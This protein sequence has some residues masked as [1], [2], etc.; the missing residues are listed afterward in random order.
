LTLSCRF[1]SFA[2]LA[3]I[4]LTMTPLV[5]PT[6]HAQS[7]VTL[8]PGPGP[9]D[10]TDNGSANAGK[11]AMVS[12]GCGDAIASGAN[13]GTGSTALV[14]TSDCNDCTFY[15]YVQFSTAGMPTTNI[16]TA[17]IYLH[18]GV[19]H[20]GCWMWPSNPTFGM[21]RVTGAWAENAITY[22]SQPA[23]DAT[24]VDSQTIGGIQGMAM[25]TTISNWV[26]F[27]VTSLYRNWVS[28][29]VPNNGVRIS[30]DNPFCQN[31]TSAWFDT[32]DGEGSSFRPYLE[33]TS[34]AAS[35][36]MLTPWLLALM[37]IALAGLAMYTLWN[38]RRAQAS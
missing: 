4:A 10:G 6:A 37:G 22:G 27:D 5:C 14:T 15:G 2:I 24:A 36:P 34:G 29:A 3:I 38:P 31:C 9:N 17:K 7:V 11:D 16:T 19:W 33:V 20:G 1:K 8:R 26:A 32:S 21:R 25:N 28:G 12:A 23:F 18:F 13:Y 30:H 35:V